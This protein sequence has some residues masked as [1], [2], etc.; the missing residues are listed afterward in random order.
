MR[1]KNRPVSAAE[2]PTNGP[3]PAT[4]VEFLFLL[5]CR[6]IL[7]AATGSRALDK[8]S[9]TEISA[10]LDACLQEHVQDRPRGQGNSKSTGR[11]SVATS[12][13]AASTPSGS[14]KG[15][16]KKRRRESDG[17]E[18]E[19][20]V[21]RGKRRGGKERD[22]NAK[23]ACP[24][25][26]FDKHKHSRC[27]SAVFRNFSDLLHHF[28]RTHEPPANSCDTCGEVF[29][30]PAELSAHEQSPTQCRTQ[31]FAHLWAREQDFGAVRENRQNG[32]H[33]KARWFVTYD[34]IF[35]TRRR[36]PE[37][38]IVSAQDF[39]DM[40]SEIQQSAD[41]QALIFNNEILRRFWQNFRDIVVRYFAQVEQLSLYPGRPFD[42][43][44]RTGLHLGLG[45]STQQTILPGTAQ[46]VFEPTTQF[47]SDGRYSLGTY[48]TMPII[49]SPGAANPLI[50]LF[51]PNDMGNDMGLGVDL[52]HHSGLG[53]FTAQAFHPQLP[54]NA[55]GS[56]HMHLP[57]QD[58]T[59]HATSLGVTPLTALQMFSHNP[60]NPGSSPATQ[61]TAEPLGQVYGMPTVPQTYPQQ[62][63]QP[64]QM[65][66][67][68]PGSQSSLPGM[69]TGLN[70]TQS[71]QSIDNNGA[72]APASN[73]GIHHQ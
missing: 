27:R 31:T 29:D 36:R 26:M 14:G 70:Q 6:G 15:P 56:T 64:S 72:S 60:L 43:N 55:R 39:M 2:A 40:L 44:H 16:A 1:L 35:G 10:F 33:L 28:G 25:Y 61:A 20:V 37:F 67:D 3:G 66:I 49:G 7:N 41:F 47:Q 17:D 5:Y 24:F 32:P 68:P 4:C 69:L 42:G 19:T 22:A 53:S 46:D 30:S 48:P 8:P 58:L 18:D 57:M 21:R 9:P 71:D 54:Q 38:C 12:T 45:P 50:D 63:A 73:F 13:P 65:N 34:T 52:G 59:G 11:A 23:F 62:P 51:F